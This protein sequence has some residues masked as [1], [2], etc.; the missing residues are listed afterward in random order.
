MSTE[1]E[2]AAA[3]ARVQALHPDNGTG[4]CPAEPFVKWPCDT[5]RALDPGAADTSAPPIRPRLDLLRALDRAHALVEEWDGD[6]A[7]IARSDA[8]DMLAEVLKLHGWEQKP[9]PGPRLRAVPALSVAVVLG[10][11]DDGQWH[12]VTDRPTPAEETP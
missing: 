6:P 4:W 1:T 10:H 7:P 11:A 9:Q 2:S 8:A 3:V 5:A 12:D